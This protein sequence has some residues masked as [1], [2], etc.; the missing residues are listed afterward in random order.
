MQIRHSVR[1]HDLKIRAAW[2]HLAPDSRTRHF[3]A[4]YRNHTAQIS[5][6]PSDLDRL[7]DPDRQIGY[8]DEPRGRDVSHWIRR[9]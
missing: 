1:A 4:G 7:G 6:D 5:G 3:A 2:E 8:V 9:P